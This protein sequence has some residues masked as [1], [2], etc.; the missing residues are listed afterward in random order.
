[1]SSYNK[2]L[3]HSCAAVIIFI[4]VSLS[5]SACF[6]RSTL[7]RGTNSVAPT[8]ST[9]VVDKILDDI[10]RPIRFSSQQLRI[11]TCNFSHLLGA[12]SFGAVYKGTFLNGLSVAVKVLNGSSDKK[13]EDQFLAEV[14]T[15]GRTHHMNLVQLYGFCFDRNLRALV[16]EFMH[17]SSLDRLLFSADKDIEWEVLHNI[18]IG[19]AKGITYLHE[20][21]HQIIIH[22][23]IKP[24]NILLDANFCPKVADFGLAMLCNR[25]KTHVTMTGGRGTPGYAAP[26]MWMPFPVTQ[27]CDVYSFGMLLFEILGRRRNLDVN[28][29]DSQE[30]FPRWVWKKHGKRRF[31]DVMIACGIQENCREKAER[32]AMVALWCVQCQPESRPSMSFALKMLEGS[33]EIPMPRNPFRHLME[34]PLPEVLAEVKGE[35]CSF[36]PPAI[37]MP[38]ESSNPGI[39]PTI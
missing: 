5:I 19:T 20:E 24:E 37:R 26:E 13:I 27:K 15:I 8:F 3:Y 30:W 17:N 34:S 21:C 22:Y 28:L 36:P 23:D 33:V 32:M 2:F 18:A 14:T 39:V 10:D 25:E 12:G 1:M 31:S 29:P 35:A 7:R 11:A 9:I 38:A 16:Y 6:R 4:R